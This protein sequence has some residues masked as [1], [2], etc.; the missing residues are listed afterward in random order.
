MAKL[1]IALMLLSSWSLRDDQD[2]MTDERSF[3]AELK[4]AGGMLSVGCRDGR[5][6]VLVAFRSYLGAAGPRTVM[7]RFDSKLPASATW[8]S[9]GRMVALRPSREMVQFLNEMRSSSRLAVRALDRT[10]SA[11]DAVF[12]LD[13]VEPA[14]QTLEEKCEPSRPVLEL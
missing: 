2:P 13:G 8:V 10:G 5:F 6:A 14:L 3:F 9:D 1:L 12:Q 4:G 11:H 7:V